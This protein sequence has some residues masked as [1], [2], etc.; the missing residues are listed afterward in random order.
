MTVTVI[1]R[2]MAAYPSHKHTYECFDLLFQISR[3]CG[4]AA[5]TIMFR[6]TY[7]PQAF[8]N[9]LDHWL[10]LVSRRTEALMPIFAVL[11]WWYSVSPD[12][13]LTLH[14]PFKVSSSPSRR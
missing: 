2:C 14:A 7:L 5:V 12:R 13:P 4:R 6:C 8:A 10:S 3:T 11:R 9:E 1:C